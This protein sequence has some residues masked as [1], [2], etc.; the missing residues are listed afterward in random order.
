MNSNRSGQSD[1]E[2][3]HFDR[4]IEEHGSVWWGSRTHSGKRRFE[5]RARTIESLLRPLAKPDSV[6][7]P[8]VLEVGCGAAA[9]TIPLLRVM[10]N[11]RLVGTDISEKCLDLARRDCAEFPHA[12]F[13]CVDAE[14]MTT[15]EPLA[16]DRGHFDAVIGNG[17]LHHLPER[18]ILQQSWEMLRPGVLVIFFEPNMMNPQVALQKNV[19]F[20]KRMLGDSPTE[21]AFF[22]WRLRN[23]LK[24][25]GYIGIV[26][27]PIDFLH[28]LIPRFLTG[29][30]EK[31]SAGLERVP[32]VREFGGSLLIKAEKR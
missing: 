24:E 9:F 4:L 10:P 15:A 13:S 20:I 18:K 22:R 23:L 6:A 16:A 31:I 30:V 17:S 29:V 21:T 26:V 1:S 19:P 11:L 27:E 8:L 25:L 32:G 7:G 14:A 3:A 2:R 12:R 5:L 28:P